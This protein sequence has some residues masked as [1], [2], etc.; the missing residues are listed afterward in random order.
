MHT[1][2]SVEVASILES[3]PAPAAAFQG[4]AWA[5]RRLLS[6]E[7]H[8]P[9]DSARSFHR[10]VSIVHDLCD[11]LIDAEAAGCTHEELRDATRLARDLHG[12]SPFIKR[13]QNWP[14][15]YPGDFE[16]IEWLCQAHNRAV[17][18]TLGS[19]LEAYALASAI[20]QQHRNKVLF[21]ADC[22][23]EVMARKPDCRVLSLACGS[24]P[25]LRAVADHVP[26]SSRIVLCDW[27][28]EA[29]CYSRAQLLPIADRC[30]LVKGMVPKVLRQ[31][32]AHGP[33]D[34]ILAGGLFDY[35]SDRAIVRTL[36]EAWTSMLAPGGCIVFTN[37]AR[38]NPFRVWLEYL[39]DW[40]LIE[41]TEDD[42]VNLCGLGGINVAPTLVRDA[43]GLAILATVR[44]GHHS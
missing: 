29:L 33:F 12:T 9:P 28:A 37:I 41:R 13:L 18:G 11:A 44:R 1:T 20:A 23:R 34:L 36:S 30:E 43:T 3:E 32:R 40:R 35:L 26:L 42:I 16:T 8:T 5:S 10:V 31:V 24:S 2:V 19:A 39:A 15:G 14:R 21:Q 17:P 27:D 7:H 22:L 4:L 6:L 25:D 38:G